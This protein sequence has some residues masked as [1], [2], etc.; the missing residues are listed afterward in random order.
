MSNFTKERI[1][2]VIRDHGKLGSTR[3]ELAVANAINLNK[4][5]LLNLNGVEVANMA[6]FYPDSGKAEEMIYIRVDNNN[7]FDFFFKED[8]GTGSVA[9]SLDKV[10]VFEKLLET[11]HKQYGRDV[12]LEIVMHY[13]V[14]TMLVIPDRKMLTEEEFLSVFKEVLTFQSMY[15]NRQ[16]LFLEN[17]TDKQNNLMVRNYGKEFVDEVLLFN[18]PLR[19]EVTD[20]VDV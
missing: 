16:M 2:E 15:L 10:T 19:V 18:I 1:Q 3:I 8:D 17:E 12:G 20:D 7:N 13:E 5:L 4:G 9:I 11:L 6:W 14:G